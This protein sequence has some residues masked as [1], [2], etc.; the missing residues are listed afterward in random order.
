[1]KGESPGYRPR[2]LEVAA[3]QLVGEDPTSRP[4]PRVEP[5]LSPLS[6]LEDAILPALLRPPC[7]VSFSGGRDSSAILAVAASVAR[8]EGVEM[9]VPTT[10]CFPGIPEADETVWQEHVVGHL[11]LTGWERITIE[12]ELDFLGEAS[13]GVLRRHGLL[14]PSNAYVH[15]PLMERARGGS[16]LTGI[17]GD[18]LFGGWGWAR[19]MMLLSGRGGRP[20]RQ[21]AR[22]LL[23]AAAPVP[24][25]R[26]VA[27]R[28]GLVKLPWLR[29]E[30]QRALNRLVA[31]DWPTE[32]VRWNARVRW[33]ARRRYV[34]ALDFNLGLLAKERDVLVVN[35][36]LDRRFLA[37]LA[38]SGGS[39]G[40]GNRTSAMR[41][42]FADLLPDDLLQRANKGLLTRVLWGRDSRAFGASWGGRGIDPEVIDEEA[43]RATWTSDRPDARSSLLIQAAWL[44]TEDAGGGAA[45]FRER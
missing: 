21:D 23:R 5:G 30:G 31:A 12:E 24:L 17:D 16:L 39:K 8:R 19:L 33:W 10:F 37:A 41:A 22:R 32:P 29:P 14:W 40:F 38:V 36:F 44:A 28:K 26:A 6:A 27:G 3:G 2:P 35:A 13:T 25:R 15:V 9:P 45:A 1:M 18:G 34:A 20:V 11:G 4:L 43:L 42:L 7:L